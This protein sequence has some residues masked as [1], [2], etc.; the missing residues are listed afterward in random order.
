MSSYKTKMT[1]VLKSNHRNPKSPIPLSFKILAACLAV[2]VLIH[3]ISPTA[4][5]R[6]FTAFVRPLWAADQGG[7]SIEQLRNV[8]AEQE[9]NPAKDSALQ[10]ENDDLKVLLGR[11]GSPHLL[12]AAILKKPPFS[13]YDTLILDVGE[14]Y[15]VKNGQKVYALGNIPIGEIAEVIGNTSKVRLYSSAGEKFAVSIGSSSIEATAIGKSGGYFEVSL[16][17]DTKIA[18]G[19]TVVAP[20]L[21]HS[22]VG[23]VEAVAS[24][25]SEPFSKMLFRQPVNIYELRWVLVDTGEPAK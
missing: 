3:L 21:T 23:T 24:D 22:F 15:H 18:V 9:S 12:L 13:A 17:R 2:L 7:T 19:D 14:D 4:L 6:L 16:P 25:P 8:L 11:A 5:P 20:T 1:Y 10:K